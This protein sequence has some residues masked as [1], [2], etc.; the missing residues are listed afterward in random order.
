MKEFRINKFIVLKLEDEKT[1]IYVNDKL[2]SQCKYL[3]LNIPIEEVV[4]I[5]E[6][7]SID[8]AAEN[9]N[10]SLE[11]QLWGSS[12]NIEPDTEFWAHCSNLQVWFENDYNTKL[13]HRNLAF[14]L[15]KKLT[16]VGDG[17]AKK[18]FKEEIAKRF[19][20]GTESTKKF[21]IKEKFID[22]LSR[23]ELWSILPEETAIL[24]EIEKR[25]KFKPI[26]C[27]SDEDYF[28]IPEIQNQMGFSFNNNNNNGV[29]EVIFYNCK[30][31]KKGDWNW[32]INSLSQLKSL[33]TLGFVNCKL[34]TL[35]ETI[36]KSKSIEILLLGGNNLAFIPKFIKNL[37]NLHLIEIDKKLIKGKVISELKKK[38]VKIHLF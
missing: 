22:I 10:H 2:F 29:E 14:P 24:H 21:L 30:L 27:T 38:G 11:S 17:K 3:L 26:I 36:Q 37:E 25:E 19:E 34:T 1:N 5:D 9:L 28:F 35:P 13:I 6:I 33:K 7:K 15:L 12:M 18:I 20:M 4:F 31:I 16:K 23:E 8:E 32:I